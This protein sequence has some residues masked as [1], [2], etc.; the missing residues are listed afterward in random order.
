MKRDKYR[1]SRQCFTWK[2][3]ELVFLVWCINSIFLPFWYHWI[4]FRQ[5][6]KTVS[7]IL[8]HWIG[9]TQSSTCWTIISFSNCDLRA[10]QKGADRHRYE[11]I[12]WMRVCVW[13]Q[14]S[15]ILNQWWIKQQF[16]FQTRKKT[17]SIT[18]ILSIFL[19]KREKTCHTL[20]KHHQKKIAVNKIIHFFSISKKKKKWISAFLSSPTLF[21]LLLFTV[22]EFYRGSTQW[23]KLSCFSHN[24]FEG[25]LHSVFLC[26]IHCYVHWYSCMQLDKNG[27]AMMISNKIIEFWFKNTIHFHSIHC[28]I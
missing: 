2:F 14:S 28:S 24:V 10:W 23:Y 18:F 4:P 27:N 6:P 7:M 1:R 26:V 15:L 25:K 21:Y 16:Y 12:R 22:I 19:T 9:T 11:W 5:W 3:I 20:K 13:L 8:N 17:P